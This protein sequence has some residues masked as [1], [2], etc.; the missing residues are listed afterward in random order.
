MT[1][2]DQDAARW[3]A[4]VD[5][6]ESVFEPLTDAFNRRALDLLG[7]LDGVDL[8]DV[9][10]GAGGAALAAAAR[11][12]R[13]AAVDAA[14]AMVARIAA[15]AA[16]HGAAGHGA[17][18]HASAGH[19][20]G[21]HVLGGDTSGGSVAG[22]RIEARVADAAALPFPA[23]SFGA[24]L[25]SFGVVL[26]PDPGRGVAE[27][28]RVLCP[29]G[30]V[31]VVTWTEPHRY[32]AATRLRDAVTAV[33]GAPPPFG[34]LPAQLRFTDPDRLRAL[35]ADAGF[36]SVRVD[37]VEAALHAPSA[38]ALA[39]SLGFAPGMAAM[40]DALGPDRDAVLH[41]FQAVL[42]AEQGMGAVALG[43]VAHIAVAV[44]P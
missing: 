26:L 14:P 32:E 38:R 25:S 17:A 44:R 35:L 29:G 24:A 7:P 5:L 11:G 15:R 27:L 3:D 21:G 23:A 12:A 6:Y 18:G 9:A 10:A 42:E 4:H 28:H 41:R 20:L 37:R 16:L 19:P 43:A 1:Q 40:L 39:A 8:V 34:D 13:V 2:P 31:A 30:R 33:R 22:G 36:A